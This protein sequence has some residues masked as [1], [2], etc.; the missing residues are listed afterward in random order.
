[1]QRGPF[2]ATI[3]A[4]FI[5]VTVSLLAVFLGICAKERT[6]PC[7]P[8][9]EYCGARVFE[10]KEKGTGVL[11]KLYYESDNGVYDARTARFAIF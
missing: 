5:V 6:V 7:T 10:L 2:P 8:I 9:R 11:S 4:R 3:Y 1:M